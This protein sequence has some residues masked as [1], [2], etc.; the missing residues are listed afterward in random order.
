MCDSAQ[1]RGA[2]PYVL[3]QEGGAG[4]S[5]VSEMRQLVLELRPSGKKRSC[6]GKGP[7]AAAVSRRAKGGELNEGVDQDQKVPEELGLGPTGQVLQQVE[8][9]EDTETNRVQH[10]EDRWGEEPTWRQY[11]LQSC[12]HHRAHFEGSIVWDWSF[13]RFTPRRFSAMPHC[14]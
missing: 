2:L 8:T 10:T 11:E 14:S 4:L 7:G 9:E 1:F 13:A 6:H 12:A 3:G 5:S